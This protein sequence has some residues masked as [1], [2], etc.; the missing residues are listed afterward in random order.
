MK[1]VIA[2]CALLTACM[3]FG[4]TPLRDQTLDPSA[5]PSITQTTPPQGSTSV[6]LTSPLSLSFSRP[7][8]REELTVAFVQEVT[9]SEAVWNEANTDVSFTLTGLQQATDY[10]ATIQAIATNNRSLDY[11]LSFRTAA[12]IDS[13]APTISS[14]FPANSQVGIATNT[15]VLITFSEA[16]S[17]NPPSNAITLQPAAGTPVACTYSFQASDTQVVCTPTTALASNM[18]YTVTVSSGFTDKKGNALVATSFSFTTGSGSDSIPP[19][20]VDLRYETL[21]E[22]ITATAYP[23]GQDGL[24]PSTNLIFEFSEPMQNVQA[25][26]IELQP[27]GAAKAALAGAFQS[28][29]G[30]R[31]WTFNPGK[32]LPYGAILTWRTDSAITD[33]A[34]LAV[35]PVSN[36]RAGRVIGRQ[37]VSYRADTADWGNVSS[38]G[39][40]ITNPDYTRAGQYAGARRVGF[41]SFSTNLDAPTHIVSARLSV[42]QTAG[43]WDANTANDPYTSTLSNLN[44]D[45]V[46]YDSLTGGDYGTDILRYCG[47]PCRGQFSSELTTEISDNRTEEVKSA[48]VRTSI[49]QVVIHNGNARVQFRL[50]FT[51]SF[52]TGDRWALFGGPTEDTVSKRPLLEVT[53]EHLLGLP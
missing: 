6:A 28:S 53:Y 8:V 1:A 30:G 34:N 5:P 51:G 32:T 47:G 7:M 42:V 17:L 46:K 16:M 19:T 11:L 31:T 35:T 21:A 29:N 20:L 14:T 44:V 40:V 4:P 33:L 25:M 24:A 27:I 26:V 43:S 36:Q 22:N 15:S 50:R 37:E 49:E 48:S 41:M 10:Q 3:D 13:T 23:A 38:E 45:T 18:L 12:E 2:L 39:T 52:S 9:L